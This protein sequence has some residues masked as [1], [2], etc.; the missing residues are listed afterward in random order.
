MGRSGCSWAVDNTVCT[1]AV[2]FGN[3]LAEFAFVG[4]KPV[5]GCKFAADVVDV[6]AAA[7]ADIGAGRRAS[8]PGRAAAA[9]GSSDQAVG[10]RPK[11]RE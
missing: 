6:A 4:R 5:A 10:R 11:V 2:R 8:T 1:P 9:G 3:C 7:V